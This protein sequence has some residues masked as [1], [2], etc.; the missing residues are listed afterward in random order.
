[1][2]PWLPGPRLQEQTKTDKKGALRLNRKAVEMETHIKTRVGA[3]IARGLVA[4]SL[5]GA[6]FALAAG[7][8]LPPTAWGQTTV[9]ACTEADLRTAMGAGGIV[10]F[11]CEGTITLTNTVTVT[12]DTVLDASGHRVTISGGHAVRV[13]YVNPNVTFALVNLSVANGLNSSGGGIYIDGGTVNATNCTFSGNAATGP[14]GTEPGANG[15]DGCGG[16]LYNAGVFNAS[17]CSFLH[18]SAAGG[19]G[20]YGW[21]DIWG[22]VDAGHGGAAD[23][24]A[25][26][27]LGVMAIDRSLFAS[28]SAAAGSGGGGLNGD[29]SSSGFG[30]GGPGGA[31]GDGSG[32]ALF[33]G[34]R[35]NV[36]NCTF[37]WNKGTGGSGGRG[38]AGS[39]LFYEYWP[40]GP[41]GTGGSGFGGICDTNG[42]VNLTNC[43]VAFN[44]GSGGNGGAGGSGDPVGTP[45]AN[46]AAGGG[47]KTVGGRLINTLL[48]TNSPGGNCFGRAT[49]GGHNLCS[50]RTCA[51]GAASS[52]N[53]TD[54]KLGPLTD[55]GGPTLT[56][57]LLPGSPAI[58][59]GDS[60]AAPPT[61]QRGFPRPVG[62]NVDIGAY[63]YCCPAVLQVGRAQ[64]GGIDIVISGMRGQYCRL[65]T[66]ATL[67][68]WMPIATNEIGANGTILFHSSVLDG[69][70][71]FYRVA[72]P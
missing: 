4:A 56:M 61:D 24:G 63:E 67:S 45:G 6:L 65:L 27:N 54:P 49:D 23:G 40:G 53:G 32:G 70:Q 35:A 3:F 13:F 60:A 66:S 51:F 69:A 22:S 41:G 33:N 71:R 43:T 50:D 28:N 15:A 25:I 29:Q 55:N 59:A 37:A 46:G 57:A 42:L 10:T 34:G 31:G 12:T 72:S 52:I 16:A 21:G 62:A 17:L 9:T 47:M 19:Q 8:L 2:A 39:V 26:F 5:I 14:S 64:E 58:D 30:A 1:M 18:N 44:S 68:N 7:N 36:A 20:W 38:G 11:A 48:A